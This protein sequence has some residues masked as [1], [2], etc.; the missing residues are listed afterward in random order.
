MPNH[1]YIDKK[2]APVVDKIKKT[3]QEAQKRLKSLKLRDVGSGKN[4]RKLFGLSDGVT[5]EQAKLM[6]D[7]LNTQNRLQGENVMKYNENLTSNVRNLINEQ[8]SVNENTRAMLAEKGLLKKIAKGAALLGLGAYGKHMYDKGIASGDK[9]ALWIQ[10]NVVDKAKELNP[11]KKKETEEN[12]EEI[13]GLSPDTIKAMDT[14]G[15]L[16]QS[17]YDLAGT[18]IAKKIPKNLQNLDTIKKVEKGLGRGLSQ[19]GGIDAMKAQGRDVTDL[20]KFGK[21]VRKGFGIE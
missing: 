16:P 6:I 17:T 20:I 10:K 7:N 18:D 2:I 8:I 3:G 1:I 11:F 15:N 14:K 5:N 9:T 21:G 4:L 19:P 13:D 12:I